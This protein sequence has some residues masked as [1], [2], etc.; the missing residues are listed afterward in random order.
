M[1]G[2]HH[3][4]GRKMT[5]V[6][7]HL[8]TVSDMFHDVKMIAQ[9]RSDMELQQFLQEL[10]DAKQNEDLKREIQ[11][12]AEE[13]EQM[14]I[15]HKEMMESK[16]REVLA[17][18]ETHKEQSGSEKIL[19][20]KLKASKHILE[21][22]CDRLNAEIN[23]LEKQI[24]DQKRHMLECSRSFNDE[25]KSIRAEIDV[26]LTEVQRQKAKL[27]AAERES[28]AKDD[29]IK[30]LK[31]FI[32]KQQRQLNDANKENQSLREQL[33]RSPT[34]IS[35]DD[36]NEPGYFQP[37]PRMPPPQVRGVYT[38]PTVAA[39]AM[40][41][42][43]QQGKGNSTQVTDNHNSRSNDNHNH[44][45]STH[46]QHQNAQLHV[47]VNVHGHNNNNNHI[48]KPNNTSFNNSNSNASRNPNTS[49]ASKVNSNPPQRSK[50]PN[51]NQHENLRPKTVPA[52]VH[53][54]GNANAPTIPRSRSKTPPGLKPKVKQNNMKSSEGIGAFV[55]MK[56]SETQDSG[57]ITDPEP[58]QAQ[59]Q[60][61]NTGQKQPFDK[62][63]QIVSTPLGNYRIIGG[64]KVDGNLIYPQP[65]M[66]YHAPI[67]PMNV[68]YNA[69]C[70]S[71][72]TQGSNTV[73]NS[74]SG[75]GENMAIMTGSSHHF[76]QS[77]MN[78][79]L[80][81]SKPTIVA[82]K[83]L[84]GNHNNELGG[85]LNSGMG[86]S[87]M[88]RKPYYQSS[89]SALG[90]ISS[91]TASLLGKHS[92]Y[93]NLLPPP[94][95]G[96]VAMSSAASTYPD[97]K[98]RGVLGKYRNSV[99]D[100]DDMLTTFNENGDASIK[101]LKNLISSG[102]TQQTSN[103]SISQS[104]SNYGM[105]SQFNNNSAYQQ[106]NFSMPESRYTTGSRMDTLFS[107]P[108]NRVVNSYNMG[109]IPEEGSSFNTGEIAPHS[110]ASQNNDKSSQNRNVSVSSVQNQPN[111]MQ[112]QRAIEVQPD[113]ASEAAVVNVM[114]QQTRPRK[115]IGMSSDFS[116]N[117]TTDEVEMKQLN[118][119]PGAPRNTSF[120]PNPFVV[121]PMPPSTS[122]VGHVDVPELDLATN[123]D[124]A[125][126][127]GAPQKAV[128]TSEAS[129]VPQGNIDAHLAHHNDKVQADLK[130]LDKDIMKLQN[131]IHTLLS[132][133]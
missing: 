80:P 29:Q 127:K 117:G 88:Y 84:Y 26:A 50:T 55:N 129:S 113:K 65:A 79:S 33:N 98:S 99:R 109:P 21:G 92:M 120:V 28:V 96:D 16:K 60:N 72:H 63:I 107:R 41:Q 121:N 49:V 31:E 128:G 69:A 22:D 36:Y 82:S 70:N 105:S 90:D 86:G 23:Q 13:M 46:N 35:D 124:R 59:Q 2:A 47:K 100:A 45:H 6:N 1:F 114:M 104:L 122:I 73:T 75:H 108:D 78:S 91:A 9:R 40:M 115:L 5:A 42:N 56:T 68:V 62:T 111:E 126:T 38:Q 30:S 67:K 112:M 34:V 25:L 95:M 87:S 76:G 102:M 74:Q 118:D 64:G 123:P 18:K 14:E 133:Q 19:I 97:L 51:Q 4:Q 93:N 3:N 48:G 81:Y 110:M 32:N 101:E 52:P 85:T 125:A 12:L 27:N 94:S 11:K 58:S 71:Q 103:Q 39:P 61:Q 131:S 43:R 10:E 53:V 17:L 8:Q 116:F 57:M 89:I 7:S 24:S 132:A 15:L 44:N 66:K 130:A 119:T 20:N 37:P 77:A 83:P 54:H 106:H